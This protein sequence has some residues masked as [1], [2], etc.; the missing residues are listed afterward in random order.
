M[1]D[2]NAPRYWFLTYD[3]TQKDSSDG[4]KIEI[5]SSQ[6]GR[7]VEISLSNML[8]QALQYLRP[9]SKSGDP[10][11]HVW[12][13]ELCAA[14]AATCGRIIPVNSRATIPSI[15][16]RADATIAWLGLGLLPTAI[17]V[18]KFGIFKLDKY[19]YYKK[20]Q[21]EVGHSKDMALMNTEP[22]LSRRK[23]HDQQRQAF[24]TFSE[25]RANDWPVFSNAFVRE[26][27]FWEHFPS[28]LALRL[29]RLVMFLQGGFACPDYIL[30][31]LRFQGSN[32][33]PAEIL[34]T[35]RLA[36][37]LLPTPA[38]APVTQDQA[39]PRFNLLPGEN[40]GMQQSHLH[41]SVRRV[42]ANTLQD[43]VES[44]TTD[45]PWFNIWTIHLQ[46]I[47]QRHGALVDETHERER[48]RLMTYIVREAAVAQDIFGEHATSSRLLGEQT[49]PICF[50]GKGY[51][52]S[53]VERVGISHK[54]FRS[55]PTAANLEIWAPENLSGALR[56]TKLSLNYTHNELQ[57]LCPHDT[58]PWPLPGRPP[59]LS[60]VA[61][62][63]WDHNE[64]EV[65]L[66][67]GGKP[68][69]RD[70]AFKDPQNIYTSWSSPL[71]FSGTNDCVGLAPAGT[72]PGD[73]VVKFRGCDAAL[74]FR[75]VA[76]RP[77]IWLTVG[78]ADVV[79]PGEPLSRCDV[80]EMPNR[81]DLENAHGVCV[82][83]ASALCS[84][85]PSTYAPSSENMGSTRALG[86]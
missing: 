42:L 4:L 14:T 85:S 77:G 76:G 47:V 79:M 2:V 46:S 78:R 34:P 69:M 86:R 41:H 56:Y 51:R 6:N 26:N 11:I 66:E 73:Y 70:D 57:F 82:R 7:R 21:W 53:T 40:E 5:T 16:Q 67:E 13:E 74:I 3:T 62:W 44:S 32:V 49:P 64:S 24:E 65:S 12:V 54:E 50:R 17:E 38:S 48:E 45:I 61:A 1:L 58:P 15:M 29:S 68:G 75:P 33:V 43:W 36:T 59:R 18:D 71:Y 37:Q 20:T 19:G 25:S 8:G 80:I 31:S 39:S 72:E 81:N 84:N 60:T 9:K 35:L 83:M 30:R 63:A 22:D 10:T 27:P 52:V 55:S 28:L 23:G